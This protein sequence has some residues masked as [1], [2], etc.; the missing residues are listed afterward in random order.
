M[1]KF[2][3]TVDVMKGLSLGSASTQIL[4]SSSLKYRKSFMEFVLTR[5][6]GW[7]RVKWDVPSNELLRGMKITFDIQ[8]KVVKTTAAEFDRLADAMRR[9]Y[10]SAT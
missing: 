5:D 6:D 10:G 2:P 8:N 9:V 1:A 7:I 3:E 4:S